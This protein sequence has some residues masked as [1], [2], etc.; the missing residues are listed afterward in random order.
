M[1][2]EPISA[3]VSGHLALRRSPGRWPKGVAVLTVFFW[4]GFALL[5]ADYHVATTGSDSSGTGS[6]SDPWATLTKAQTVATAG[7]TVHVASGLYAERV[8]LT[9]SGTAGNPIS[10]LGP[11]DRSATNWGFV[12]NGANYITVGW[13][14]CS[15]SLNNTGS[16]LAGCGIDNE[17]HHNNIISNDCFNNSAVGIFSLDAPAVGIYATNT[18]LQGNRCWS[19]V[20]AG[21]FGCMGTG[22]TLRWNEVWGT[23]ATNSRTTG[24]WRDADGMHLFGDGML[25]ESNYIHGLWWHTNDP[26]NSGLDTHVDGLQTWNHNRGGPGIRNS[27]VRGNIFDLP[28]IGSACMMIRGCTN[29][30]F[31]N[32]VFR[33][34][35]PV[36][37]TE[38][39]GI[40][41]G[42][43]RF[44]N[45]TVICRQ[46]LEVQAVLGDSAGVITG[47]MIDMAITNN[48]FI[49]DSSGAAGQMIVNNYGPA[50]I[51]G[52][53]NLFYYTRGI[54]KSQTAYTLASTDIRDR[55]PRLVNAFGFPLNFS[56]ASDSPAKDAGVILRQFSTDILGT[57]RPQGSAWDIGAVEFLYFGGGALLPPVSLRV[58][59]LAAD[60]G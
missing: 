21:I 7:D 1:F 25:V 6:Q 59:G 33:S 31:Y 50:A 57:T 27:T 49:C 51:T 35:R 39:A 3:S 34:H 48:L 54:V 14:S 52:G 53:Y 55:D 58:V 12:L 26:Y 23:M 45:N 24:V 37:I 2:D 22:S 56:I 44:F 5:G 20:S 47:H 9:R 42:R 43:I 13:F 38:D 36:I 30:L 28:Y 19:N 10:F 41:P 46:N 16:L 60:G 11:S 18:L 8:T 29:T 32:N 15:N 40:Y 4:F 17:G